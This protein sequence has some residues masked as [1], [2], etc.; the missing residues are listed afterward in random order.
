M[1]VALLE[2]ELFYFLT[3][4]YPT[5]TIGPYQSVL[6]RCHG[7]TTI[8]GGWYIVRALPD[9]GGVEAGVASIPPVV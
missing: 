5:E 7:E 4:V 3:Y 2:K 1:D 9:G 6:C 8:A